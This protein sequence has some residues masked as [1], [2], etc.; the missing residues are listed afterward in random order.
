MNGIRLVGLATLGAL[1]VV[2]AAQ[3]S[4]APGAAPDDAIR[5]G[6]QEV[7]Y[8]V[9]L[10]ADGSK[11]AF[12]GPDANA[13]TVALVT[14]LKTA[15][16]SSVG[17]ADGKPLNLRACDWSGT[18][19]LVCTMTGVTKFNGV[20]VPVSR[21]LAV[22]ASGG[23]VLQLGQGGDQARPRQFD[24]DIVDWQNGVD[25]MVL[26]SRHYIPVVGGRATARTT[27]GFGVDRMDT[28]TGKATEVEK[29]DTAAVRYISDGLGT[30]RIKTLTEKSSDGRLRG[31]NR[32][33][34]R[35]VGER[36]WQ[37]LGVDHNEGVRM[38]PLAVDPT[39][40]AAYVVQ[41]LDGRLAL[42]RIALDGSMKTELVFASKTV[43]VASV[44]R[45]GR[46]GR[47]IGFSYVTDRRMTQY[48]DPAYKA[49]A[50]GLAQALPDLPLMHFVSASADE[51][52]VLVR[53]ASD[54]DPGRYYLF[55]R[56]RKSLTSLLQ[57]RPPLKGV[58]LSQVRTVDYAA[59]DGT[60][61]PAYL[62]LPP[63][64]TDAK[65]LPAIVMP[66]GGPEARDEWGFDWLAQFYAQRGFAVLQPNFRGSAGYG[67]AWFAQNGFQG[68]KQ[69]IGDVCDGARWLVKQGIAD[70]AKLAAVGWSYGGYAVLQANVLDAD[71][72]K[73][74]IAIAPVTDLAMLKTQAYNFTNYEIVKDFIGAGPHVREG[75]PAQQADKFKAPVLMF[76]GT[77][78]VNVDIQ[79]SQKMDR[80]LHAAGKSSELV[81]YQDLDH[82][83]RS[84]TARTDML[85]RS[86]A[87][88]REHLKLQ[89]SSPA[90]P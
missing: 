81:T 18:N 42:Y 24:G 28:T 10:S 2:A 5:F 46:A 75:S 23:N 38:V 9:A 12:V 55:D 13:G 62:T 44:V 41:T 73:A 52:L 30:I 88:L 71:L 19:R 58:K 68:W 43:D 70:P 37:P 39:I 45:V 64:V 77:E 27:E 69:S 84:S 22:D 11:L 63:G 3:Q 17:R 78:D 20:R 65:G 7:A 50:R 60:R 32:H 47:V 72:F 74:V 29:P 79:Q 16:I 80:A 89:A 31:V 26:M 51:H 66:H 49:I 21:M 57:A 67:D 82:G 90:P 76:H 48:F 1:S 54:S 83:L 6:T 86:D 36:E 87:F 56:D 40:N 59:A 85:R 4:A 34:Y 33:F 15:Q 61:I 53:A 14:D 25:G 8:S 35:K